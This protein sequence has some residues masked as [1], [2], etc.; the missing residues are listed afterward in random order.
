MHV[1]TATDNTNGSEPATALDDDVAPAVYVDD[2]SGFGT[3]TAR[4]PR[5]SSLILKRLMAMA[6]AQYVIVTLLIG[7]AALT[8]AQQASQ[9]IDA[10]LSAITQALKRF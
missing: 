5:R 8:I 9:A 10:K 4:R 6:T 3:T 7:L 1:E 2:A